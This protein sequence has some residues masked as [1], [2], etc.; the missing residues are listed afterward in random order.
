M[1][2]LLI[3]LIILSIIL[4]PN[5]L[6]GSKSFAD[7]GDYAWVLVDRQD[8]PRRE[9]VVSDISIRFEGNTAEYHYSVPYGLGKYATPD[10][11]NPVDIHA[12]YTW[13]NPPEVIKADEEIYVPIEQ[14]LISN[15]QGNTYA[16]FAPN[17]SL[18]MANVDLGYGTAIGVSSEMVF[19]DGSTTKTHLA[20]P[21]YGFAPQAQTSYDGHFKLTFRGKSYEGDKMGLMISV[22]SGNIDDAIGSK[23]IYE[24]KKVEVTSKPNAKPMENATN[25][26]EAFESGARVMWEAYSN[27]LG[28]RLFRSTSQ[29][30]LGI[31][32]TDFY[33]TST[34]YADVNV[35]PST[36]YYYTVKPV[37][38]EARPFDGIDE[39]LGN[40]ISSFV[41]T[42]GSEVYRP[43]VFKH[44]ILLRLDSPYMSVD[45]I[46]MEVDEGRETSPILINGRSMVPIRSIVEVMG[47]DIKWDGDSQKITMAARDNKI[48]MWINKKDIMV[49]GKKEAMDVAPV[50]QNS[51][52]FLPI[53]FVGE[54]LRCKVDWINST[55]EIVIVYED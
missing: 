29:N 2:K 30:Q 25:G 13:E 53:R 45:G 21:G 24:W 40:T 43:G 35:E 8:Y 51:R 22:S 31:S 47:G 1:K 49:N 27:A 7:D 23:Y 48:E 4:S 5:L 10:Y 28:Y 42:T 26:A 36:T 50:I 14:N 6:V 18:D 54:N 12:I 41:V 34:S 3:L 44:F 32:V 52:T 9:G 38:A 17:M 15:K 39:K 46:E 37:L 33:I 19:S 16:S 20:G 55:K 11:D